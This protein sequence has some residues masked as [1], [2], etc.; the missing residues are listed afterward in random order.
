MARNEIVAEWYNH[1]VT[2]WL[3]KE[4]EV[5]KEGLI[6]RLITE[7]GIDPIRDARDSGAILAIQDIF[8][9]DLEGSI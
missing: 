4:L 3:L 2:E 5:R 7:A 6:G 9:I 1:P 8:D